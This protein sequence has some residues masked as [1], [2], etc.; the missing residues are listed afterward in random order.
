MRGAFLFREHEVTGLGR[1]DDV[2]DLAGREREGDI[3][4]L[5][6]EHGTLNPAPIA[7]LFALG[8]LG[9][10]GS[11]LG[12]RGTLLDFGQDFPGHA[13]R[14]RVVAGTF[15]EHNHPEF[16]LVPDFEISL[17]G[18]VIVFNFIG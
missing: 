6:A 1:V 10:D 15:V 4:Q 17:M 7:A 16:D 3:G 18:E 11:H 8:A 13:M 9:I 5:L 12:E 2:A 14:G